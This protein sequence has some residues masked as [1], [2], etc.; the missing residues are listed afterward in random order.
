M[1]LI[2]EA[3]G[4]SLPGRRHP[5]QDSFSIEPDVWIVADGVTHAPLAREAADVAVDAASTKLRRSGSTREAIDRANR[6]VLDRTPGGATQLLVAR[7]LGGS[8]TIASAGDCAAYHLDAGGHLEPLLDPS[9]NDQKPLG[10]AAGEPRL[11]S[12]LLEVGPL[13]RILLCTDG[14]H[15]SLGPQAIHAAL[16][17]GS[18]ADAARMVVDRALVASGGADDATAIVIDVKGDRTP[19]GGV[20]PPPSVDDVDPF[21]RPDDTRIDWEDPTGRSLEHANGSAAEPPV[22]AVRSSDPSATRPAP[23]ARS[24]NV[25]SPPP[26]TVPERRPR[27]RVVVVTA[28]VVAIL[29]VLL[30]GMLLRPDAAQDDEGFSWTATKNGAVLS[31]VE[32]AAPKPKPKPYAC[33]GVQPVVAASSTAVFPT[34]QAAEEWFDKVTIVLCAPA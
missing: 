7:Y 21:A 27:R 29:V 19:V 6:A 26:A 33:D 9:A 12:T 32:G 31:G 5:L 10:V 3:A 22:A 13:D 8:L 20:D 11:H 15:R 14:V 17:A 2:I 24:S 23:P 30:L 28:A 18:A 34:Q 25:A 4:A 16:S 1:T